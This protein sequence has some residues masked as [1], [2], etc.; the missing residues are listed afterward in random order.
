[1]TLPILQHPDP[2]LRETCAP[3]TVFDEALQNLAED[4]LHTMYD[5]PGRGLAAPQVGHAIRLFVMDTTW[6]EEDPTPQAF[7]NPQ[8]IM[9]SPE[10]EVGEEGC[11]SLYGQTCQVRRPVEV[12]LRYQDLW[13]ETHMDVFDGFAARCVQHERDHLDGILCIDYMDG[14]AA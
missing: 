12:T 2:I 6:K 13:G 5:A 11:L 1:M 3:V 4:M 10:T 14:A 8:I 9:A 7:V